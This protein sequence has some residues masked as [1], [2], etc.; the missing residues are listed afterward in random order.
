M[1]FSSSFLSAKWKQTNHSSLIN[2]ILFSLNFWTMAERRIMTLGGGR[3]K[4][5]FLN[6]LLFINHPLPPPYLSTAFQNLKGTLWKKV[7][8]WNFK[9]I[10]AF[11][12]LTDWPFDERKKDQRL[13]KT[14]R[15]DAKIGSCIDVS[16]C[17][18]CS[19][20]EFITINHIKLLIFDH[21]VNKLAVL[22]GSVK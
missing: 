7:S 17:E 18:T 8:A 4:F 19:K 12:Y 14:F 21:F 9:L 15:P 1:H 5:F 22:Y 6:H 20:N 13:K 2:K 10:L 11:G 16:K 3:F